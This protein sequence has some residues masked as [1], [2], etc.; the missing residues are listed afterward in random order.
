M[1]N[2][3][4]LD[5]KKFVRLCD[6]L[7]GSE[8][9]EQSR[10]FLTSGYDEIISRKETLSYDGFKIETFALFGHIKEVKK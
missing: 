4:I 8:V 3:F 10:R 6:G 1:N 7:V 5:G 2:S 9:E